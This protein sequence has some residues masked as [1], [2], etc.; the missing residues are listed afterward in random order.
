MLKE[1]HQARIDTSV[2]RP[3]F[4]LQADAPLTQEHAEPAE[5]LD[6]RLYHAKIPVGVVWQE[7]NSTFAASFSTGRPPVVDEYQVFREDCGEGLVRLIERATLPSARVVDT[8]VR[9]RSGQT[10]P[11]AGNDPKNVR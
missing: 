3:W 1:R 9:K 11:I 8:E 6:R 4:E 5:Q 2:R 7:E 10:P